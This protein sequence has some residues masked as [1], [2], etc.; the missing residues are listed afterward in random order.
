M[1]QHAV[2]MSVIAIGEALSKIV[3]TDPDFVSRHPAIPWREIVG[4]RNRIAH[5]YYGLDFEVVWDTVQSSIPELLAAL[6]PP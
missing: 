4:M 3:Q 1:V 6:P 2:A 5:G